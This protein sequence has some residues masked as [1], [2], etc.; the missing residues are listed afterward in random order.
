MDERLDN[1]HSLLGLL[2]T[3]DRVLSCFDVK[4]TRDGQ[5]AV[6]SSEDPLVAEDASTAEVAQ[7]GCSTALEGHLVGK[8]TAVGVLTTDNASTEV[9]DVGTEVRTT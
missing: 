6:P 9:G 3:P 8:F 1:L 2:G 4:V 5:W 7:A